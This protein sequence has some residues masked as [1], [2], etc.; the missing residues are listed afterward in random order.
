[1]VAGELER[2]WNATLVAVKVIEAELETLV[3]QRPEAL[4]DDERQRLLHM[5]SDLE[6]AW[7][8]PLATA[9][10]RKRIIRAV[11]NEIVVR[12]E[13]DQIRLLLHWQGGD[14]TA[15][16]VKKNR[17]GQ[18]RWAAAPATEELIRA[19]ARLMPDKAIASLLNR[20]GK[21]TGRLNGWTQSRVCIF[22]NQHGIAVYREGERAARGEVTLNEAADQIGC[23][24]MTAL[25]MI[26]EGVLAGKQHCTGAPWII[27]LK[28]VEAV[29][30]GDR[31]VKRAKHPLSSNPDQTTIVFQ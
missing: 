31:A 1:M 8:H 20:E 22:R 10:T 2:R 14:H 16:T 18:H 24:A 25:R 3:R 26:R 28:D 9:A 4:G 23:S 19:L 21:K 29:N 7:D 17:T 11:L 6:A 27:S 30:A 15:L 12:V 5:G 13:E